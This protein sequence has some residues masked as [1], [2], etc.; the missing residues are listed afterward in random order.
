MSEICPFC[1]IQKDRSFGWGERICRNC[2]VKWFMDRMSIFSNFWGW[3]K[4]PEGVLLVKI[5]SEV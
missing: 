3:K 2:D 1:N 5:E 4:L